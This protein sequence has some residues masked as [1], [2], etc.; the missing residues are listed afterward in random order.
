[1]REDDFPANEV[2]CDREALMSEL[3]E[4]GRDRD[5]VTLLIE[6]LFRILQL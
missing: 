3:L 1:M 5:V 6:G 2:G 4:I